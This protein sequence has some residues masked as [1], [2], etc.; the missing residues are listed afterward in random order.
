M[1]RRG[2][3]LAEIIT[4]CL[5]LALTATSKPTRAAQSCSWLK[6]GCTTSRVLPDCVQETCLYYCTAHAETKVCH[7]IIACSDPDPFELEGVEVCNPVQ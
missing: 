2:I 4:M 5:C 7:T 6:V 1:K 3:V